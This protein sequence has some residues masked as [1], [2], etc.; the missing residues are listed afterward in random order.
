MFGSG[1]RTP[2]MNEKADAGKGEAVHVETGSGTGIEDFAALI[3][4]GTHLD[5][6]AEKRMYRKVSRFVHEFRACVMHAVQWCTCPPSPSPAV[7]GCVRIVR[8][9]PADTQIV[10]RTLSQMDWRLLPILALLYLV[11]FLDR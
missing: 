3:E 2:P 1:N 7:Q 9:S 5:A 11:A 8:G 6:K 4:P 10:L